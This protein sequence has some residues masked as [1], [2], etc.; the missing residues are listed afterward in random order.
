LPRLHRV[1]AQIRATIAL[2]SRVTADDL[3]EQMRVEF[4]DL[5]RRWQYDRD[6][7]DEG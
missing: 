5:Y 7:Q 2:T 4:I 6:T 3:T 1:L